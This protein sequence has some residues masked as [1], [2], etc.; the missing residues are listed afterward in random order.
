MDIP[1]LRWMGAGLYC[2]F[3]GIAILMQVP[4]AVHWDWRDGSNQGCHPNAR[5]A[6]RQASCCAYQVLRLMY[7]KSALCGSQGGR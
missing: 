1:L 6:R 5:L 2:S 3:A 7:C 4:F